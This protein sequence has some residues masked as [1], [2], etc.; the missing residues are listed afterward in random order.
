LGRGGQRLFILKEKNVV[1]VV[2][3]GGFD[4]GDIDN[5]ILESI[6]S[7]DKNQTHNGELKKEVDSIQVADTKHID[8]NGFSPVMLGKT[9]HLEANEL[10]WN[11]IRFT[12]RNKEYYLVIGF[13]DGS[14]EEH[15]IG[16]GNQYK[17]S[18]EHVFGLP[19][20][21]RSFW[22]NNKLIV[23]YNELCRINF[24]RLTFYFNKDS[25]DFNIQDLTNK[26]N[27]LIKGVAA[28]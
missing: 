25:I 9:F 7:Y 16:M 15:P 6:K 12:Q 21:V 22:D 10:E 8:A 20:A 4:A 18:S 17:I 23:D 5:L 27:A 14:K 26:R 13:A 1:R 11:T 2:T 19:T 24:Y 3:G 28:K